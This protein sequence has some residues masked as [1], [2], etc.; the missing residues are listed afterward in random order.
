MGLWILGIVVLLVAGAVGAVFWQVNRV[1]QAMTDFIVTQPQ[2]TAV[3]TYTFDQNGNMV[4]DD[5]ALFHNADE[6]LV[7]AS[8]MKIAV[9]AAY[10]EAVANGDLDPDEPV[11]VA[12]WERF[13][14]PGSDGGAHALGLRRLALAPDEMGFAV[15]QTAVVTLDDLATIMMHYSG[16]AATDYLLARVGQENVTAVIQTHL[17]HHTPIHYTLGYALAVFNHELPFS[18]EWLLPVQANVANGDFSDLDRLID[19][20]QNDA[21]WRQAQLDFIVN[22]GSQTIA[23][24][25]MWT[26]QETAVQL[27]PQGTA[28][29]YAQMMAQIGSGQFISAD[30]SAL[31]QQKMATV[32]SDWPLR[33]L[34]FDRFAAKDGVTA[35][36]LS[37]AA[38]AIPK[39]GNLRGQQRVV[40]LL[41]NG[42]PLELF[43]HQVQFQGHYLLPIDL[44]QG[45]THFT[46]LQAKP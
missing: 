29:D 42:L 40:I 45:K 38:Y 34:Y 30:V 12:E 9:L 13:Y 35:G 17:P 31:M 44:A 23:G 16:N 19:L 43:A 28:R 6:P 10:A 25:E 2:E 41:T 3:V 7:V 4:E 18:L 20:Y 22:L 46:Q 33:L 21:S 5:S 24:D 1:Q 27:M 36:V 37:V 26:Y 8:V 15:D 39:R 14:L 32:A 11:P